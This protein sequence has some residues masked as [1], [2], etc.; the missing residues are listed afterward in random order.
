MLLAS[1]G[2]LAD[3]GVFNIENGRIGP[4]RWHFTFFAHG[5]LAVEDGRERLM[6]GHLA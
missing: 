5:G 1:E 6:F 4:G 2:R 3:N